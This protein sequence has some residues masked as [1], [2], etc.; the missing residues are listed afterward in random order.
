M[1]VNDD[2]VIVGLGHL[3]L[4]VKRY[5]LSWNLSFG[6]VGGTSGINRIDRGR[7]YGFLV[8][9]GDGYMAAEGAL[10]RAFVRSMA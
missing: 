1:G 3:G 7:G 6:L 2:N 4:G 5:A 10:N 8:V 9:H